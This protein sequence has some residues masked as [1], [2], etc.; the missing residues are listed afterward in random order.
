MFDI[1]YPDGAIWPSDVVFPPDPVLP[2]APTEEEL[3]ALQPFRDA[4]MWAWISLQSLTGYRLSICPTAV[5]P[6]ALSCAQGQSWY[7]APVLAGG[8]SGGSYWGPYL[9]TAGKWVNGCGCTTSCSC[10]FISEILLDGPVGQIIRVRQNGLTLAPSEYRVDNG[11]RLVRLDGEVWPSCQD[12]L[13]D[14]GIDDNT[15]E[16]EYFKGFAPDRMMYLAAGS[17]AKEF[18]LDATGKKC[19]LPSGVTTITRMGATMEIEA[20]LFPNGFTGIRI[21]DVAIMALNPHALKQPT[22]MRSPDRDRPRRT[23]VWGNRG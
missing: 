2:E 6:C 8:N 20:G 4:E 17:L 12:M 16:V 7:S 18:Y 13:G 3:A 11:N 1:C 15:L 9:N 21:V 10:T 23:T 5:R 14:P 22:A 19:R